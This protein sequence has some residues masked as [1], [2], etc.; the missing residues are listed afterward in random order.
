MKRN[1]VIQT[2]PRTLEIVE[3]EIPV[4]GPSNVLVQ[5]SAVGLCHSDMPQ[6]LGRSGMGADPHGRR[7]IVSPLKYPMYIGHEPVGIVLEV[8][9][10]VSSLRPGDY[11]GG[12]LGGFADYTVTEEKRCIRVPSSV[13]PLKYCLPEPLTCIANILQIANPQFGDYVAVIGCGMMGLMTLAG[14]RHSGAAELIAIDLSPE[15]LKLAAKYGAT[16]CLCP[17]TDD[18]DECVYEITHGR[19]ADVVV[20]ITGSLKGLRTASQIIRYAEMFDHTGRGK[21]V[22]SSLY[23]NS[24]TWDPVTGY[25]LMF[26]SPIVH[27]AH[28]WYCEDYRRT[29]EAGVDAY[30]KGVLPLQEMITHEFP[31][32]KI[33]D[34]FET[35]ASGDLSYLKGIVVP[36]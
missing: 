6:Y 15:R 5:I 28:P 34:G 35:M 10:E 16:R 32:E 9:S 2:A 11:V 18:V 12:S 30:V 14:L 33:C 13:S 20:E 23:G 36:G 1:V 17:A 27:N 31:L 19:G 22:V 8:G 24:E 21:L 29:G 7:A 3:E 4:L 26:R 25:N